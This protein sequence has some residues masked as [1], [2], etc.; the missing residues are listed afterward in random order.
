MEGG[1]EEGG[2]IVMEEEREGWWWDGLLSLGRERT[3]RK[4]GEKGEEVVGND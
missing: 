3:G 2:G 4:G 1:S